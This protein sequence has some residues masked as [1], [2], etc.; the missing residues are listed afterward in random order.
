MSRADDVEL[1]PMI[2]HQ[3]PARHQCSPSES[4]SIQWITVK[5]FLDRKTVAL[6]SPLL[7]HRKLSFYSALALTSIQLLHSHLLDAYSDILIA[8]TCSDA[9]GSAAKPRRKSPSSFYRYMHCNS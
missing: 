9:V 1:P 3:H 4:Y 2:L 6:W 8:A 5:D 7:R